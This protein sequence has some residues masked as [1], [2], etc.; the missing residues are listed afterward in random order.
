MKFK[1]LSNI[2]VLKF[3]SLRKNTIDNK[4]QIKDMTGLDRYFIDVVVHK[5]RE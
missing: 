1:N 3:L 5:E 2:K 4:E